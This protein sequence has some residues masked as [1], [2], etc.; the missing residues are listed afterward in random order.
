[1]REIA[2]DGHEFFQHTSDQFNAIGS[3]I[4]QG[5]IKPTN[6]LSDLVNHP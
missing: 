5:L 3:L 1:M 6:S 4:D 2:I